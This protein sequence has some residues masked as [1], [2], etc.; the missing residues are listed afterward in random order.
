MTIQSLIHP[1]I[2]ELYDVSYYYYYVKYIRRYIHDNPNFRGI[3]VYV[4]NTHW[5]S[6]WKRLDNV[7]DI[8]YEYIHNGGSKLEWYSFTV[9][10]NRD[11]DIKIKYKNINIGGLIKINDNIFHLK[12]DDILIKNNFITEQL[13][14][15]I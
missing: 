2:E 6:W 4:K 7:I 10:L 5:W 9:M 11:P 12:H 13:L 14:A 3:T 8:T 1:E 15:S